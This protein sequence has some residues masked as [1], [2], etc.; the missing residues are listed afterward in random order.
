MRSVNK[1]LRESAGFAALASLTLMTSTSFSLGNQSKNE[2]LVSDLQDCSQVIWVV[3][4][5]DKGQ[6]QMRILRLSINER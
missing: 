5:E 6:S 4:Q 1:Y 2:A 3:F